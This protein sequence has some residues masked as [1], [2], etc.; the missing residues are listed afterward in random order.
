MVWNVGGHAVRGS[1]LVT[2]L[3]RGGW[4]AYRSRSFWEMLMG[5]LFEAQPSV[6][7]TGIQILNATS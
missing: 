1:T 6:D 7:G 3:Q 5:I 4:I 2:A